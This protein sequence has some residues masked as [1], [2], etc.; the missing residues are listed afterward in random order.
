MSETVERDHQTREAQPEPR[1]DSRKAMP[2]R[3]RGTSRS[4]A[5]ILA[6]HLDRLTQNWSLPTV[7]LSIHFADDDAF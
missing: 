4:L 7:T 6:S 1:R 3:Y 5:S 2:M